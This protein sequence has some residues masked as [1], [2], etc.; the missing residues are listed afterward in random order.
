PKARCGLVFSPDMNESTQK[1]GAV[2]VEC[3]ISPFAGPAKQQ[4]SATG[5]PRHV[6]GWG[7]GGTDGAQVEDAGGVE[8]VKTGAIKREEMALLEFLQANR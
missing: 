8:H 7:F 2:D 4:T 5:M 3:R 1:S 6:E